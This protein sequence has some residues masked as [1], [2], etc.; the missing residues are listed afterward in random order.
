MGKASR[1]KK[2]QPGRSTYRPPI[3]FVE[4]P[5][6]GLSCESDL[7]AMREI[8]PCARMNART[9]D[10]VEFDI[11]SLLPDGQ[12]AMVRGDGRIMVGMQTRFHSGDLSHDVGGALQAALDAKDEGIVAFD[13]RDP[14]PR[15]QELLESAEPMELCDDFSFW[16]D[17]T[18]EMSEDI[19]S[20]MEQTRNELIPT[21]EVPG[22]PGMYWCEMNRNFVRY[23]TDEDENKLFTALARMQV[24]GDA[25]V[26]EGSRFV[27]AFRACGLAIPV[28]ELA[29]GVSADDVSEPAQNFISKLEDALNATEALTHDERRAKQGLVSRQVT[30]R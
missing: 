28:F 30:I 18:E 15:L 14:A 12:G 29:E 13:V 8:I 27:G 10:G 26:G 25:H 9:K 4:R 1:R 20:T 24:A 3:R 22:A 23:V 11:V 17:P 5:F 2:V 21:Q 16:F 19:R 7:V 6:E